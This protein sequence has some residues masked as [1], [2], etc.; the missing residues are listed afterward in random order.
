MN[1][2]N[3]QYSVLISKRKLK[4]GHW[5]I[6]AMRGMQIPSCWT[7]RPSKT[8]IR[9]CI[10]NVHYY[11]HIIMPFYDKILE[12]TLTQAQPCHKNIL[13]LFPYYYLHQ[14]S[15]SG[16]SCL[17]YRRMVEAFKSIF[18]K[19]GNKLESF[20]VIN[21]DVTSHRKTYF[22]S[23]LLFQLQVYIHS[24]HVPLRTRINIGCLPMQYFILMWSSALR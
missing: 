14:Q 8:E 19:L 4:V 6:F 13:F 18:G 2:S 15:V 9:F 11:V 1:A 16:P 24:S 5:Y 7:I 17:M 21:T 22:E 3:F 20:Y 10:D 12:L 23:K